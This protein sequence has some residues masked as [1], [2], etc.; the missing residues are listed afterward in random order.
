M[1]HMVYHGDGHWSRA[2]IVKCVDPCD[3]FL[4]AILI[5]TCLELEASK[6]VSKDDKL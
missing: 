6:L 4:N 2:N 5:I 1:G 3:A